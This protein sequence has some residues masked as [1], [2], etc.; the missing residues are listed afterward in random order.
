MGVYEF[1]SRDISDGVRIKAIQHGI[2]TVYST[3]LHTH[4]PL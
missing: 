2:G 4:V 1:L 3:K